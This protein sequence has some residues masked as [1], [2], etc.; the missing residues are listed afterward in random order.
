MKPTDLN[1][2]LGSPIARIV[3]DDTPLKE[4]NRLAPRW[5]FT[6]TTLEYFKGQIERGEE[7]GHEHLQAVI[8]CKEPRTF[9]QVRQLLALR[10]WGT[11][12]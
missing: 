9:E 8:R 10:E 6:S 5:P 12:Y 3:A 7:T 1:V 4:T 11:T 2:A